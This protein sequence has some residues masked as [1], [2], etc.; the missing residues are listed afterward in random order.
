MIN[1]RGGLIMRFSQPTDRSRT[2]R[3][4][5]A[6]AVRKVSETNDRRRDEE[7]RRA[8]GDMQSG[9][10]ILARL[11][12][13]GDTPIATLLQN[14]AERL[15]NRLTDSELEVLERFALGEPPARIAQAR[16]VSVRTVDNQLSAATRKLDFADRRELRGYIKGVAG[17]WR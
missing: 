6:G 4:L 8:L 14:R 12:E 10:R 7:I 11:F 1:L 16:S 13:I 5:G 3:T 17:W 9:L 15:G 2:F